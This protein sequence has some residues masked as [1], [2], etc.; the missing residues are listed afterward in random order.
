MGTI[1]EASATATADRPPGAL[2]LADA[3][4]RSCLERANRSAD[5]V[6]LLINAGVYEDKSI[7]EPAI[8]S[9]IQEDIG[10]NPEQHAGAGQ[11]TFSFDVRNGACG[12]LTG[13]HLVDGMLASGT[14]ELGMVVASDMDPE[15]G[16]SEGFVFPAAGGA[17][18][19]SADDARPGFS[20]FEFETFPEF[21][22]LFQS[23]VEWQE[24]ARGRETDH[25]RN[26][27]TVEIAESYETRA[28]DC[29]EST[30]RQVSA[31]NG[32]DLSQLD[33]LVATAS[34]PGFADALAKRLGVSADRVASPSD[35]LASAHTA[36]PAMALES[37]RLEG[38]GT[39]LFVS[40]GAG[41]TVVAALYRA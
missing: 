13:I 2:K 7:S 10:A 23:Y 40:T 32:F 1:I 37:V 25:G 14:V 19:L 28:V 29:A 35:D 22:D 33:L 36:A 4:A 15:P 9:L 11:G 31:A 24:D 26:I 3:A 30:A 38:V 5:E 6:D 20:S 16:V 39:A 17:V 18:L 21:A 34:V 41:I 12:L 8:A 27:L